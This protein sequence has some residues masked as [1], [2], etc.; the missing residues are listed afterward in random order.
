MFKSRSGSPIWAAVGVAA[1]L[2]AWPAGAAPLVACF[3]NWPPFQMLRSD[4]T[5]VG[6]SLELSMMALQRLGHQVEFLELPIRRCIEEVTRG[7]ID[8]AVGVR[9]ETG[10]ALT[11]RTKSVVVLGLFVGVGER[12]RPVEG[13]LRVG[14][15]FQRDQAALASRHPAWT[16]EFHRS[17]LLGFRKLAR[18]HV[19]AVLADVTWAAGL[20][21]KDI[22][23]I[24]L[25]DAQLITELVHEGFRPGL[26]S[27][28]DAYDSLLSA[29]IADGLVDRAY[30]E[31]LGHSFG[32]IS[33]G[34][35]VKHLREKS[36][37][38]SDRDGAVS[39]RMDR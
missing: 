27:L 29:W 4:G 28:R 35:M 11:R 8:L 23:G 20:D 25:S 26:E 5:P 22:A 15:S 37:A 3:A 10:L 2:S 33:A 1:L 9:T 16:F 39:R 19:D 7:R 30:R 24:S 6:V 32:E 13:P 12:R 17:D 34:A 38:T 18:G 21:D 14:I 31:A 36:V